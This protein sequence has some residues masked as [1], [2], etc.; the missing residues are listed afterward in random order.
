[1][2][3]LKVFYTDNRVVAVLAQSPSLINR[4]A[5]FLSCTV[6]RLVLGKKSSSGGML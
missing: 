2:A 1:M 4:L 3:L 6:A 5:M